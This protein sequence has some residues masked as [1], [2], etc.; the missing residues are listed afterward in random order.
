MLSAHDD[1][2]AAFTDSPLP[3]SSGWSLIGK[4][5]FAGPT[6]GCGIE[7]PPLRVES[8]DAATLGSDVAVAASH[9]RS[10][11]PNLE[12]MFPR[13][14]VVKGAGTAHANGIY[15][16]SETHGVNPR[17]IKHGGTESIWYFSECPVYHSSGGLVSYNGWYLSLVPGTSKYSAVN[18]I[19]CAYTND[20][21][22]IPFESSKWMV[23]RVAAGLS[24]GCGKPPIPT[25]RAATDIEV[26]GY[27][28]YIHPDVE[29][30]EDCPQKLII[31]S[32]SLPDGRSVNVDVSERSTVEDLMLRLD[33]L[34]PE[35]PIYGITLKHGNKALENRSDLLIQQCRLMHRDVILVQHRHALLRSPHIDTPKNVALIGAG[36]VGMY[37]VRPAFSHVRRA[38][39]SKYLS[40]L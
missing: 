21:S 3:P 17:Y 40:M 1:Y 30:F 19:Y 16:F 24:N 37:C 7:P 27:L 6:V 28:S 39:L 20:S 26:M 11:E 38:F 31:I 29:N 23:P 2:Y 9:V 14:I 8:V 33:S 32:L 25:F 15:V 5:L 10:F 35:T 18:D 34:Y 13:Y 4:G 22:S 36:P 12:L